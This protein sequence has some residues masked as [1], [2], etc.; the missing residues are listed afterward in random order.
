MSESEL[1]NKWTNRDINR[2]TDTTQNE[3]MF[4]GLTKGQLFDDR[5]DRGHE[6][7]NWE[8]ARIVLRGLAWVR[9]TKAL[10]TLKFLLSATL[11][12]PSLFLSWFGKILTDH[13]LLG[14]PLAADTA[15]F[16]SHVRPILRFLEGREPFEIAIVLATVYVVCLFLIGTRAGGTNAGLYGGR[17]T[18]SEVE[19]RISSGGSGAGGIVGLIEFWADVRMHQYLANTLRTKLFDRLTYTPM[20]TIDEQRVGD[21]LY[22]V[23]YDAPMVSETVT[24]LTLHPFHSIVGLILTMYQ[25]WSAYGE[26]QA[27]I[28]YL[29]GVA[30]PVVFFVFLPFTVY[31]RRVQHNKRA[32]GAATTNSME[33]TL[34]NIGAVQSLGGMKKEKEEFAKRSAHAYWRERISMVLWILGGKLVELILTPLGFIAAFVVSEKVINGEMTPGDYFALWGLLMALRGSFGS[35]GTFWIFVQDNVAAL[36][37]VFFFLDYRSDDDMHREGNALPEI[38]NELKIEEVDFTYPDGR[39]ALENINL[40]LKVNDIVAFVGP[41]GA[42]KT[43]LAYLIPAFLRPTKGKV[44]FDGHDI[45]EADLDSLRGQI[46][47]V[48]QEHFLLAESIRANLLLAKQDATDEELAN[49]LETAGCTEF[50]EKL[51]EGIDT[52]LGRSGDT[53]SVGQQQRLSIARGLLRDARILIL[54][55]PT[56]AL[57]PQT[58]NALVNALRAASHGKLVIVIAHRLSTIRQADHIVF[59]DEGKIR[60]Q[61][62]HDSM[63]EEPESPYREFV[64]LQNA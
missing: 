49:A 2:T 63:M 50:V 15:N 35:L 10:F 18:A 39:V 59:L 44:T 32:A 55:E 37:R 20:T 8:A 3:S 46:A 14:F 24:D 12:I 26:T 22:R 48:F 57:D 34:S 31:I 52:V 42:G 21:S 25:L 56:A 16:P 40:D 27:W 7:S 43:S 36:R 9:Y 47:F 62:T 17:D 45:S 58:E 19:N 6:V 23:L 38:T 11:I 53:L 30:A 61:G 41:T 5:V 29:M 64:E 28:V 51:P 4:E 1:K 13:V 54:D 33:E 60:D